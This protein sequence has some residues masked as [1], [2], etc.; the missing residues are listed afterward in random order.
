MEEVARA[1]PRIGDIAPQFEALT[2][3][4]VLKLED[5]KG[6]WLIIF[7][8]P[9][10]FTPVCTT[11][12]I[13]F[14]EIYP[15]LQKRGVELLGLSVDSNSS[16]IAWVRNV[17]DKTG[18][19]IPFPIIAD[20]NKEV[21]SAYGMLHPGQSKT[22]T[23]RCVF[24]LDPGQKIRLIM[25][26]PMNVGRNMQEILRVIDALQ[27]ADEYKVALPAN[28]HPGDKVVVPSPSTQEMAEERMGQGY[29]CVD[30]YL[31]K[32]QL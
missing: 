15:E 27:T 12:F 17:E 4:G 18:I 20:L 29:E 2:T 24:I 23:V 30:W 32:K 13:A 7:S 22:E 5:F 19:K 31:C 28:W 9:A 25:Y 14:T 21:S 1:M 3:H 6:Q 10:D 16:H 11:E 8:H 26:Y